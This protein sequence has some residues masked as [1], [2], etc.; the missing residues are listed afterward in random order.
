M[1]VKICELKI[2]ELKNQLELRKLNKTGNKATLIYRLQ[3]ALN[4]DFIT[5]EETIERNTYDNET[6]TN[7]INSDN[8]HINLVNKAKRKYYFNIMDSTQ[9]YNFKTIKNLNKT[10]NKL[11]LLIRNLYIENKKLVKSINNITDS[12]NKNNNQ[13]IKRPST[14]INIAS[15]RQK[16]GVE[17]S[18]QNNSILNTRKENNLHPLAKTLNTVNIKDVQKPITKNATQKGSIKINTINQVHDNYYNYNANIPQIEK[19][20]K[21]LLLSDSY[22][23][24]CSNIFGNLVNQSKM[25]PLTI[26]KPNG[27]FANVME[28]IK[29]TAYNYGKTDYVIIWAGIND[30]LGKTHISNGKL[31]EVASL[32]EKTNVV[33]VSVP[34]CKNKPD[35][36]KFIY[37][38]NK[39]I[40][41]SLISSKQSNSFYVDVNSLFTHTPVEEGIHL[42]NNK[43][44]VIFNHVMN[45][46][47]NNNKQLSS[48]LT[49]E[50]FVNTANLISIVPTLPTSEQSNKKC[51]DTGSKVTRLYPELPDKDEDLD[52][53]QGKSR[54]ERRQSF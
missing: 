39:Q 20:A 42:S 46:I 8:N 10:V 33:V 49:E 38:I 32:A 34:F 12:N 7:T 50:P 6:G 48:Y 16:A 52:L 1:K 3:D 43:K 27:K 51:T 18:Q 11:Q 53:T 4:S 35:L 23:R 36:N 14:D 37:K 30:A 29:S 17:L 54:Y 40:Y 31:Q 25:T 5:I 9:L 44:R 13:V 22:G 24:N 19:K 21:V 41:D 2:N 45:I 26:F 15:K 47:N 28:D